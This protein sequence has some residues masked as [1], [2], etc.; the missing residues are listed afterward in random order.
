[1]CHYKHKHATFT[2]VREWLLKK[3]K[4]ML[5][6]IVLMHTVYRALLGSK[7]TCP[8]VTRDV[9][10]LTNNGTNMAHERAMS[11]GCSNS[12][13]CSRSHLLAGMLKFLVD[14]IDELMLCYS[15]RQ[16]GM[17]VRLLFT[18]EFGTL[19]PPP[20]YP[21]FLALSATATM[22][23]INTVPNLASEWLLQNTTETLIK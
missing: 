17:S 20:K 19:V 14:E 1:M 12:S 18:D 21:I 23:E 4:I 7:T 6:D 16:T 10:K 9:G 5:W 8:D 11:I 15:V 13:Q 22:N 2:R 3:Y